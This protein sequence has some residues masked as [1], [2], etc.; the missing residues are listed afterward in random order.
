MA[1]ESQCNKGLMVILADYN[2]FNVMD[3]EN[4]RKGH[5]GHK[6]LSSTI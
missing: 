4:A 6:S 5:V 1:W 2:S 3:I